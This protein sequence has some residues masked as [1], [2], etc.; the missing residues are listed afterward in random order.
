MPAPQQRGHTGQCHCTQSHVE[1]FPNPLR[2][3]LVS[4][5]A[6]KLVHHHFGLISVTKRKQQKSPQKLLESCTA[7]HLET[8]TSNRDYQAGNS[9]SHIFFKGFCIGSKLT[10]E[11]SISLQDYIETSV[12]NYDG[13]VGQPCGILQ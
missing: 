12:L 7:A 9:R 5:T 3:A 6:N 13:Y 10:R 1:S 2:A 11:D 8:S 4:L